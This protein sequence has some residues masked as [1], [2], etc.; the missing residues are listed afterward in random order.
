MK[1]Y[2]IVITVCLFS[3]QDQSNHIDTTSKSFVDTTTPIA[4]DTTAPMAPDSVIKQ[5]MKEVEEVNP[6]RILN[7]I[8]KTDENFDEYTLLEIQNTSNKTITNILTEVYSP[9]NPEQK[10]PSNKR[11]HKIRIAPNKKA[12]LK[13]KGDYIFS[14]ERIIR[15][16]FING[17]TVNY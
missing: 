4:I 12:F 5:V 17:E 16:R 8:K 1:I 11:N 15:I 3:C 7:L 9:I 14:N 13:I 2:I 6:I 10:N